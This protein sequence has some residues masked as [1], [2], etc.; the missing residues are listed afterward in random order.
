M[1]F[2]DRISSRGNVE[3]RRGFSSGGGRISIVGVVLILAF[4]Y[5]TGGSIGDALYQIAGLQQTG[6]PQQKVTNQYDGTDS[7]EEFASTVLGS[8]NDVW[9]VLFAQQGKDYREPKLVLFRDYTDSECGGADSRVGPHYCPL[10]E[11]IYLDETFFDELTSKLGARGGDVAQAYVISHEVGHHVQHQLGLMDQV[12]DNDGSVRLELQADC[13]AGL[14]AYSLRDKDI[15]EANEIQEAIDAA[16]A[17]GDDRIQQKAQGYVNP[18]TWTHGS[19]EQRMKWFTA[20]YNSGTFESC[21]TF[22]R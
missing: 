8:D 3:D 2:W 6:G 14:W 16:A 15:F 20:G 9:T 22:N 10:D 11:T 13:Y 21:D 7:Y 17:V 12:N 19:S 5:F 1:A 4:N 18:E